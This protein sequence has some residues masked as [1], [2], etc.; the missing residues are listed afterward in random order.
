MSQPL[1]TG[2]FKWMTNQEPENWKSLSDTVQKRKAV[3]LKYLDLEYPQ[4]LHILHSDY[5][6]APERIVV[7]II[8]NLNDKM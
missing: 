3:F 4:D 6:Q 7:N 1:P 8:L 2:G 5:P